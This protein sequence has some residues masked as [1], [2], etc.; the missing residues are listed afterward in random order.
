MVLVIREWS[1]SLVSNKMLKI[2]IY[3]KLYAANQLKWYNRSKSNMHSEKRILQQIQIGKICMVLTTFFPLMMTI[4]I[5]SSL[6][7][8]SIYH[9][10]WP[11]F[12]TC[13]RSTHVWRIC[14]KFQNQKPNFYSAC[15]TILQSCRRPTRLH[16]YCTPRRC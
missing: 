13:R 3:K 5:L 2:K 12:V 16:S 10:I 1:R 9:L 11:K 8:E 14:S 4:F 6:R 15:P 7:D